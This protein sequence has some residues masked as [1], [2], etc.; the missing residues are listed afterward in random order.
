MSAARTEDWTV[1]S[2]MEWATDYF[3]RRDIPD[4]RHSIEWLLAEVLGV[5]RLDLYLNFDRPLSPSEL[6][7]LRPLVKR[8]ASHEPLQ[9]ITGFTEFMNARIA[10]GPEVLIPRIETEQ[11]VEILLEREEDEHLRALDLGTGSGCIPIALKQERPGWELHALELSVEALDTAR[12]NAEANGTE[13]RFLQGD[14]MAWRELPLEGPF[15]LIVSNPPYVRPGEKAG[16][17]LQVADHEPAGALYCEDL[18][19]MYGA[20]RDGAE[21]LLSDG[22]RLYLEIH[23]KHPREILG[24]FDRPGWQARLM[25]DYENKPRFV[26]ASRP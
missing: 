3:A 10:V 17:Q 22:G 14:L 7:E 9:Y 15:D 12:L 8:R 2:M 21:N 26:L 20:I 6:E 16:L 1:L 11:L 25:R 23:E 4:P 13:V 24:L 18:Q 5:K 19:A